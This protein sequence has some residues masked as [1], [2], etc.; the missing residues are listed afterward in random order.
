[1]LVTFVTW[2]AIAYVAVIV[3][4]LIYEDRD[5]STT[6]AWLLV[7]LFLPVVGIPLYFFFGRVWPWRRRRARVAAV[8]DAA[9][10]HVLPAVYCAHASWAK[11]RRR[12][13]DG[14]DTAKIITMIER[15]CAAPPLPAQRVEI[16]TDGAG[17]FARLIEDIESARDHVHLQYFIWGRDELTARVT[18]LLLRKLGEGV[19]VRVVYDFIGSVF[20]GKGEL[21]ALKRA[22]AHVRADLTKLNEVNYRNH[23]KIAII[24]GVAGY[25][26]GMNMAQEYIDGGARFDTWRDTHVRVEGPFVAEMQRLFATRWFEGTG[27]LLFTERYFPVRP[28]T[29]PSSAVLCQ[30]VH[31]SVG[32]Q[33][34]AIKQT[35]LHAVASADRSIRIQSPYFVPDQAFYD[36]LITAGLS[37][38]DA[39]FMMTGVPD[40]RIPFWAAFTYFPKLLAAGVRVYQYT[41]GF[42]HAKAIA[43]DS[44]FCAIGTANIDVR[45]FSLHDEMAMFIYDAEVTRQVEAVFE[46]DTRLSREITAEEIARAGRLERFRNSL[47]RLMSRV[48]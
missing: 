13:Y 29:D 1:M 4:L 10:R 28:L 3:V 26:G 32:D 33:W 15:Q 47:V 20:R 35:F 30:M 31:S 11:E 24:D 18:Q 9:S 12:R 36:G 38:I 42:F 46:Y 7:L 39:R 45:S 27:E 16:F 34:E 37:G 43:V 21:R 44:T 17:K 40:K 8:I 14:T 48:L 19:E 23:H 41:A 22:G 6:L 2:V 25:T 5:P